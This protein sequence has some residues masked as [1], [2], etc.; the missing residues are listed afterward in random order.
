MAVPFSYTDATTIGFDPFS[1]LRKTSTNN[2]NVS[3]S[4][5][6]MKSILLIVGIVTAAWLL[7]RILK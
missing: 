2:I 3:A 1:D 4:G 6:D 5:L 7:W